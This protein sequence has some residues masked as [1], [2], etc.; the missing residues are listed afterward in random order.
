MKKE[1][2]LVD[3]EWLIEIANSDF[4][5]DTYKFDQG[6]IQAFRDICDHLGIDWKHAKGG[7]ANDH[8]S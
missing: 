2:I 1:L 4:G 3:K 8:A 6:Y 7:I 5:R